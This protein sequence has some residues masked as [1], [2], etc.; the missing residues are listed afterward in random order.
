MS[1]QTIAIATLVF[2]VT[3][4]GGDVAPVSATAISRRASAI[5]SSP[6]ALT[7]FL[8]DTT[9]KSFSKE[10]GTQFSHFQADGGYN[11]VYP[12]NAF[13]LKGRWEVRKGGLLGMV[14]CYS[15]TTATY[16]P[17]TRD[18]DQPDDW[19]CNY[20]TS[21]LIRWREIRNGDPL[22]L[23]QT[24]LLPMRLPKGINLSIPTAA[25]SVGLRTQMGD[26]KSPD[27]DRSAD[28]RVGQ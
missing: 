8:Q 6:E 9:T 5:A 12:G 4:C 11:L 10:H 19:S 27:P 15:Y 13:V 28:A 2:A 14:I 3:A 17:V 20:A 24:T 18:R 22:N 7:R 23:A 25:K 26:N 21:S 1:A 16:N